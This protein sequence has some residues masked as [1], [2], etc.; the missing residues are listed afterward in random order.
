MVRSVQPEPETNVFPTPLPRWATV[1]KRCGL[2]SSAFSA[3]AALSLL[4]LRINNATSVLPLALWRDRLALEAAIACLRLHRRHETEADIRDATCLT[5]AGEALG[6]AGEMFDGWRRL[7]RV[8]IG[9][10]GWTERIEQLMPVP[11]RQVIDVKA[12]MTQNLSDTPVD[13]AASSLVDVLERCPRQEGTALMI[14][15]TALSHAV[16]WRHPVPLLASY[17]N[18]PVLSSIGKGE[19]DLKLAVYAATAEACNT[20]LRMADDLTRR[21]SRLATVAPRLRTKGAEAALQVFLRHDAVSPSGML[22]PQIAGSNRRMTDRSARR[23]C[24]RL[25]ELGV[26]RELT[27]R[28]SFRLYGL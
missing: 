13:S 6:P 21:V 19:L 22:S 28:T 16:G 15:D 5:R 4:D 14:A 9:T 18:A 11:V 20:G 25:V 3:G 10:P 7:A 2:T 27:G 12:L 26:A 24:D 1:Q 23:F 8:R 17:L